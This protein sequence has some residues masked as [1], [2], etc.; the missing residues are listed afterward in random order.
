MRGRHAMR[1]S[2]IGLQRPVPQELDRPGPRSWE[3]ANLVVF[4]M[5]HQD[6]T[7]DDGQIVVEL[8]LGENSYALP[9]SNRGAH[10]ALP[11]PVL[12]DAFRHNCTGTVETIE[13]NSDVLI[14]L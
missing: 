13:R 10:H 7:V 11:P 2:G 6:G 14:E 12:T 1:Q 4:A 9:V 5:H 3:G 8:G